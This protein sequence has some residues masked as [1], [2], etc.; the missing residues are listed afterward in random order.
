MH[1]IVRAQL[2]FPRQNYFCKYDSIQNICRIGTKIELNI[3]SA[4]ILLDIEN[5]KYSLNLTL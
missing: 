2:E 5:Q 1:L 3:G 4:K